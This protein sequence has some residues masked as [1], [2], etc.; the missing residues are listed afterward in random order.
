[1]NATC[2]ALPSSG[3]SL[4]AR[5]PGTRFSAI[6]VVAAGIAAVCLPAVARSETLNDALASA[7]QYNPQLDAERARL[8]ATDEEVTR[9]RS[10]FRPSKGT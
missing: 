10:G 5:K 2:L 6:A 4:I 8:R 9:A 3:V 7:Y 1:M